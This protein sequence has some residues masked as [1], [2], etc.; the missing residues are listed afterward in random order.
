MARETD[1]VMRWNEY[2]E[3]SAVLREQGEAQVSVY[4]AVWMP[5]PFD[6]RDIV[7][8]AVGGC[9]CGGLAGGLAGHLQAGDAVELPEG[10]RSRAAGGWSSGCS[11]GGEGG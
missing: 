10:R 2:I 3:E 1:L 4:A 9:R 11:C 6:S 7:I 5:W 8:D